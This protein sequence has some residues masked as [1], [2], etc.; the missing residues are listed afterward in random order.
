MTFLSLQGREVSINWFH[1]S[2]LYWEWFRVKCYVCEVMFLLRKFL[3]SEVHFEEKE[4]VKC[5]ILRAGKLSG[6]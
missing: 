6:E 5:G 3:K 2:F 4:E 1:S